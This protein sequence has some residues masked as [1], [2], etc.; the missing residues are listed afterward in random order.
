MIRF[1]YCLLF[2]TCVSISAWG[3][4]TIY[5]S[6]DNTLYRKGLE[7]L[8]KSDF[9][10]AR[11][12][13][14][15]YVA[16][17]EETVK[18]ANAE[19][20]IAFSAL[21]LYHNDGEKLVENFI[22]DNEN[23]PKALL[24]YYELGNFYFAQKNYG[25][26]VKYLSKVNLSAV[27]A[28]QR[29][30]TRFKLGYAH[31]S[32]RE[33]SEALEC[34]NVL[35]RQESAYSA[36]SS[37][38]AGYIAYENG[39]YDK[40]IADLERAQ[41][42]E[43]YKAVVPGMI[44]GS[45]YKQKRYDDLISYSNKVLAGSG[46]VNETQLYLL[47]AD[48]Y[49]N[50]GNFAEAADYYGRY[51]AQ[52]KNPSRDIRYRIGY[53]NY[54]LNNNEE[55]ISQLK[56]AASDKDS[57]G[58]YASYY[59]GILYLKEGNKI[60]AHTAFDNIRKNK[61][62][63]PLREEGAY[64][65]GK[66]N[67]DLG[68]SEE[69][70][71]AFQKFTTD[72]PKSEHIAEV[73]DLL[74]EA[75]LN[76]NNY[77]LAITHI[78][79]LPSMNRTM[80]K[81]YQK[82][83]FLKGAELFNKGDYRQS[84]T[85][86]KKSIRHPVAP[87]YAAMANLW[88]AEAY[89]VGRRYEQA[90][91]YYQAILGSSYGR[92]SSQGISARYGIGYAYYNIKDY[93]KALI[94]FKEYISKL[95]GARKEA[96]YDDALLRLADCYYI[97]KSYDNALNYYQKAIQHNE[98][99]NDYAHLQAGIVM[100]IQGNING[101]KSDYDH[102][103]NNNAT[104][105][106]YD[107]AIFQ[108]AQLSFEKGQYPEATE[109][110]TKLI[111]E[112]PSSPFVPYAY[113]R[114]A[115]SYYN[116]KQYDAA[117]EDYKKILKVFPTHSTAEEALLPLQEALNI[118]SR[119]DEFESYLSSY[120]KANPDKKGVENIEFETAKN[121]YYNLNYKKT[122][123]S[124]KSYI[125]DYPD[126]PK[127]QE[128]KFYIAESYYRLNQ[129]EEALKVYNEIVSAGPGFNQMSRVLHRIADI[130]FASERHEN[131]TYFYYRLINEANNKKE[132]Y[133]AWAG[134]MESYYRMGKYD[135]TKYYANVILE[136]GNVNISSQ[137]KA[138]LYLGKAAYAQ[139]D[140]VMA[141]DEFLSTLNTAK[142]VHGAE[143]QYML[144]QIFYQNKQYQQSIEALIEV[145]NSFNIYQEW[146]GKAYLLM[147]DNYIALDDVFQAKGTLKSVIENFP[148]EDV[149]EKARNKLAA[150]EQMEKE[151]RREQKNESDSLTIDIED[152]DN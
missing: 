107:D 131:A 130:E 76:S 26:A 92:N 37:Y 106:Y 93:K 12:T 35:K 28:D 134:L 141:K 31:F 80:E 25:K 103:I 9:T 30:E 125:R 121:Q 53:A 96:Y 143:A 99:D 151:E 114:R 90:V 21:N 95:E 77:N 78:E 29:D 41:E 98:V 39:A 123:A 119:S 116:L 63:E 69:A 148:L 16:Q 52:V 101:A 54:R 82:A 105:R 72:F 129:L 150:I 17:S 85:W 15:R 48:A 64:Q 36:V 13:F 7:L 43:A 65:Y 24:A 49:L 138:A 142:D 45:Y 146:V 100:G 71:S 20:Y 19:Y 126:N 62:L 27:S 4:N 149:R 91:P 47:T 18:K 81:V 66:I 56:N 117:I 139:G 57:I 51:E 108:K 109:A 84:I 23:H 46:S 118:Q 58:V 3:Q 34:F 14:E 40:A 6:E 44:A 152:V 5:Q 110:F 59:L 38:Y 60:Y 133:Y 88:T 115:S 68:R 122:I 75:Y 11:E 86:L 135:S 128:A 74:S 10:A 55:A 83:T 1:N 73:N 127:V 132:E 144:G 124:F 89:A 102:I 137:N 111:A 42:H 32:K 147:A 120:K 33:F 79:N 97:S 112:K 136:K 61:I 87:E 50:K 22:S 67:Y 140:F 104:S 70:I 2:L 145:N 94:H 8:N 113:M